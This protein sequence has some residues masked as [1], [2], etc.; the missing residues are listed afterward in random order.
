MPKLVVTGGVLSCNMGSAPSTFNGGCTKVTV[1]HKPAGTIMD[2]KP[3]VNVHP[4][5]LCRSLANPTVASATGAA[6]GA[7]TPMPCLPSLPG[8]WTP[9]AAR[10]QLEHKKALKVDDKL[11]CA[12]SGVI[13]VKG[14][15]QAKVDVK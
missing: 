14:A 10:S 2:H 1:Q 11:S 5:G 6:Q 3:M 12:Y 8:P 15:G 7:L 9:G 4:F 13:S